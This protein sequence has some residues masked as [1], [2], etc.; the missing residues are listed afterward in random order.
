MIRNSPPT[1][2]ESHGT[3][4]DESPTTAGVHPVTVREGIISKPSE[5]TKLMERRTAYG[6]I[7][8]LEGQQAASFR[9]TSRTRVGLQVF[10]EKTA[11][12]VR[13]VTNP[14]SWDRENIIEYGIRQPASFVPPVI[15][16]LLLNI[17]DALSYGEP[18]V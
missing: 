8:D 9:P 17:L 11:R 7:K 16:G 6:S 10:K 5:R 15:L 14:K 13:V 18:E 12:I 1:E 2:E 3:D 4:E